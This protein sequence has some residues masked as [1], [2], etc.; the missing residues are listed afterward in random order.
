MKVLFNVVTPQGKQIR[1][2][3]QYWHEI[4]TYKHPQLAGHL[5]QVELVLVDPDKIRKSR[6]DEHVYLYYR[7]VK[8]GILCVVVRHLNGEGFVVT[9][10]STEKEKEGITI[11][12]KTR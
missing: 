1:T 2:T 11:W 4:T 10:Y 9:A 3:E 6:S 5:S 12:Q 8:S 7:R